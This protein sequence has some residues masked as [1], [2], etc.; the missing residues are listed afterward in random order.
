MPARNLT[1]RCERWKVLHIHCSLYKRSIAIIYLIIFTSWNIYIQ[2]I[3][4][5]CFIKILITITELDLRYN[6]R[7]FK[8][9]CDDV[10]F[11]F[12]FPLYP[13]YSSEGRKNLMLAHSVPYATSNVVW[14][15]LTPHFVLLPEQG[16]ENNSFP[17]VGFEPTTVTF[18]VKCID[19]SI[20]W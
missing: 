6:G 11:F 15:N 9:S 19:T 16:N 20:L 3:K 10:C 14:Q 13:T 12:I 2:G 7:S 1:W 8:F 4:Q 18:L 5:N 17:Q